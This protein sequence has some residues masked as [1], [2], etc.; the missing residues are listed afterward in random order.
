[1]GHPEEKD[2]ATAGGWQKVINEVIKAVVVVRTSVCRSFDTDTAGVRVG[3]GFVVDKQ[4]GIILTS[5]DL[6]IRGPAVA[7]VMFA[8]QEETTV[9][10]IY[11]DPV[12]D[13][14]FFRYNPESIKY[15][16]YE[17]IPLVPE[18][19]C[20]GLDI[21]VIGND[22]GE[23]VS[24]LSGTLACLN[25]D[26][27]SYKKDGYNDFNTFYMQAATGTHYGS[28]GSPV[29]DWHGRAVAMHVG[30]LV[31]GAPAFFLPLERVVRALEFLQAKGYYYI[32]KWEAVTIPRGTLQVTFVYKRFDEICEIGLVDAEIGMLD[33]ANVV[34]GMLVVDS[35]VPD[36][37][38]ENHLK[39]GD[40][41][42]TVNSQ[43]ITQFLALETLLDDNV[44]RMVNLQFQRRGTDFTVELLVGLLLSLSCLFSSA[45]VIN[46]DFD[47]GG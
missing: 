18:A 42:V 45:M 26:A 37:L 25:R 1:M 4:R 46:S 30:G 16:D 17:E 31:S 15:L 20:V 28:I 39:K 36:S 35:V 33:P 21:R 24:V 19:A 34:T 44:D 32:D 12:H 38:A 13:F 3:T 14:G 10:P 6:A 40:V 43:V 9:Q 47:C 27:P 22:S 5:R 7:E 8:N 11:V 2:V 41:L 23:K 29:I